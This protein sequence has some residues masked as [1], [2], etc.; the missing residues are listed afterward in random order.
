MHPDG[1]TVCVA[2][3]RRYPVTFFACDW[4]TMGIVLT[5]P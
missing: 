2:E 4:I 1:T 3:K 5:D